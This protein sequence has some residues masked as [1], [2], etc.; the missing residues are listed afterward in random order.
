MIKTLVFDCETTGLLAN[1]LLPLDRQPKIIEFSSLTLEEEK[2]EAFSK[3]FNPGFT[4]EKIIT[5][6]TGLTDADLSAAPAFAERAKE[7]KT[8]IESA[9]EV[10]AHNLSFDKAMIDNE[11]NRAGLAVKWPALVCTVEQSEHYLGFRL[12]LSKLHENLFGEVFSGAH[13]AG[14]DVKALARCFREMR[15]RDDL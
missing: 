6:I 11:M 8:L 13:R 3:L 4:L 10:V 2:E 15:R 14:A 7:I 1:S 5:S 12:N 9:D